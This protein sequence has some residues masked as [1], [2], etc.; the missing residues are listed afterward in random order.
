LQLLKIRRCV[1]RWRHSGWSSPCGGEGWCGSCK[2][3]VLEGALPVTPEDR[4]ALTEQEL[5]AGWRLACW[6][7]ATGSLT[8]EAG[9]WITPILA[10]F[11]RMP[12]SAQPGLGIAI[13]VGTTT[14]VAQLLDL[15]S[16]EVIGVRSGLNPQ[17]AYGADIMSRVAFALHDSRLTRMIRQFIG[18]MVAE[19]AGDRVSEIRDV[20]LVGNT[21]MHHLFAGLSVEP[22]S[23]VP[24]RPR[25]L[26]E[27]TFTSSDLEWPLLSSTRVRFLRCLGSFVGSDILAGIVATGMVEAGQLMVLI[28]RT[29]ANEKCG[30]LFSRAI[31]LVNLLRSRIAAPAAIAVPAHRKVRRSI[32]TMGAPFS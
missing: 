28:V 32:F 22:L 18:T 3:R 8:L 6:A 4:A 14:V 2:V 12:A 16:G 7:C 5:A 26:S 30:R 1:S 13:D 25:D 27:Q 31:R 29:A 23:H 10:D 20:V 17:A 24:F 15:R 21:V 9:Q 11:E 19:L